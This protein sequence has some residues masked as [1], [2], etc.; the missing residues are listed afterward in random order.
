MDE[1]AAIHG[2]IERSELFNTFKTE[3]LDCAN[4]SPERMNALRIPCIAERALIFLFAEQ[5]LLSAD[6]MRKI[7]SALHLNKEYLD[8][9]LSDNKRPLIWNEPPGNL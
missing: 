2:N 3:Y 8:K 6:Q 7:V 5:N 4:P 1:L 9:R